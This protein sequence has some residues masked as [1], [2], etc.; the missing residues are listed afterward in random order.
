MGMDIKSTVLEIKAFGLT[1]QAI[2]EEVGTSQGHIS[3]LETGRRGKRPSFEIVQK[4][5]TLRDRL[6]SEAKAAA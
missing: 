4:L 1:Q 2:A 5:M 3:D 6:R